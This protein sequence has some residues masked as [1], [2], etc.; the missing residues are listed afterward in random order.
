MIKRLTE[1][2]A[3]LPNARLLGDDAE[4]T[5]IERDSRCVREGA[6]FA[7]IAGAFTLYALRYIGIF[8]RTEPH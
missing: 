2:A 1:L 8:R 5:S 6:L 4:I 3:L 7:C